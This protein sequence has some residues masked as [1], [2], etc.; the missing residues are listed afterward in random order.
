MRSIALPALVLSALLVV[1]LMPGAGTARAEEDAEAMARGFFHVGALTIG[2]VD[3]IKSRMGVVS[4]DMISDE[5]APLFGSEGE[6]PLYPVGTV[7]ELIEVVKRMVD[8][9]YWEITEGA[10]IQAFGEGTLYVQANRRVLGLIGRYLADLEAELLTTVTIEVRAVRGIIPE[11][12]VLQSG[13]VAALGD[14]PSV[15]FTALVGQQATCFSGRQVSFLQDYDVEV[16]KSAT[17]SDPIVTVANYGL[18]VAARALLGDDPTRLRLQLDAHVVKH[19]GFRESTTWGGKGEAA[20]RIELP[21]DEESSIWADLLLSPGAWKVAAGDGGRG[22]DADWFFLVRV[23]P[24]RPAK[25]A[26]DVVRAFGRSAAA[27]SGPLT[28]RSFNVLD[29]MDTVPSRRG[30]EINLVPSNYTPPEPLEL[31]EPA[32]IFPWQAFYDVIPQLVMPKSW[33]RQGAGIEVRNGRLLVVNTERALDAVGAALQAIR[34][35]FLWTIRTRAE[36]IA[37]DAPIGQLLLEDEGSVR[38]LRQGGTRIDRLELVCPAD[39]RNAVT[40]GR[41]LSYLQDF[42]VEIAEDAVIANPVVCSFLTGSVLDV[43]P[44]LTS[45]GDAV[46]M[47]VQ[48][49]RG[50]LVE[51]LRQVETP[52]GSVDVPELGVFRLRTG[53]HIPL[54]STAVVGA[55]TYQGRSLVLLLTP[56]VTRYDR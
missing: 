40:S 8:P 2:Q 43:L 20:R 5:E 36:L 44:A 15:V 28:S 22:P 24:R 53:L 23:T 3:Y 9:V 27:D 17:I 46:H 14:G 21:M 35:E 56:T 47:A 33:N 13:D 50:D 10:D 32:P 29:L 31:R 38:L 11:A 4:P 19:G 18:G 16:A 39:A 34:R 42:E 1:G 41:R 55:G 45:T 6:E 54:G 37:V 30:E 48:F 12:E 25:V 26:T 51:P 49:T 52:H 7:D